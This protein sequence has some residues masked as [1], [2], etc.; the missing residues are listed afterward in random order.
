[1]PLKFKYFSVRK[2]ANHGSLVLGLLLVLIHCSSLGLEV[3]SVLPALTGHTKCLSD[4]TTGN[5]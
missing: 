4:W 2:N 5:F 3:K 1:M